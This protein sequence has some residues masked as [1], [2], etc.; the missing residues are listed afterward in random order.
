MSRLLWKPSQE[1]INKTLLNLFMRALGRD[2]EK[3]DD[4]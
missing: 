2:F 4:P 1:R 3:A